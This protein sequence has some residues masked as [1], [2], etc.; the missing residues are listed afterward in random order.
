MRE[1]VV[2]VVVVV[3][4]DQCCGRK[5]TKSSDTNMIVFGSF[6]R[7]LLVGRGK[8]RRGGEVLGRRR[9]GRERRGEGRGK[10]DKR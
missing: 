7:S 10:T 1:V 8:E 2:V 4:V 6:Q 3:V 5:R 9:E